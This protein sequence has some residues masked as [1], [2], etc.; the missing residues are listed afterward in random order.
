MLHARRGVP[1]HV[2]E[3]STVLCILVHGRVDAQTSSSKLPHRELTRAQ[4][5][6]SRT[7][8]G[9]HQPVQGRVPMGELQRQAGAQAH[10]LRP[11]PD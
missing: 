6:H 1:R 2:L 5:L 4:H 7:V 11:R 10:S 9:T 8:R 3:V